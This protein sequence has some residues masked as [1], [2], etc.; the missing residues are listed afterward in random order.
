MATQAIA[1]LGNVFG[2]VNIAGTS[3]PK[4]ILEISRAE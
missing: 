4:P 3:M 1:E 2:L